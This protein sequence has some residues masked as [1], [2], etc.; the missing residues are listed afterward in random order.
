MAGLN[1]KKVFFNA[2]YL[3]FLIAFFFLIISR[4]DFWETFLKLIF[5]GEPV[6]IY[7]R[8]NLLELLKEHVLLVLSSSGAA[9]IIGVLFGIFVTRPAGKEYLNIVNDISSLAQ[10]IP[11][12]AVLALAIPFIG[13]GFKPTVLAL[14]LYSILPVIRNTISGL[15]SVPRELLGAAYGMG[16]TRLQILLKIEIPLSLKVIMAGIRTSV[17]INVGTATVGAVAGAGGLGT[18]IISGLVRENPAFVLEGA[19][20]AALLA[21]VLD[22]ILGK[23]EQSLFSTYSLD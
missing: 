23:T 12:V 20:S 14:F 2:V 19:I 21:F 7:P 17:V 16:M 18:P 3:F 8:A 6:V 10:T 13:F 1:R 4:M 11:P 15:D 22:Q 9:V 5:P